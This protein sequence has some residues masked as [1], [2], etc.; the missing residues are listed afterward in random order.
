MN[1][2]KQYQMLQEHPKTHSAIKVKVR[3]VAAFAHRFNITFLLESFNNRQNRHFQV[4]RPFNHQQTIILNK[5]HSVATEKVILSQLH[6][7]TLSSYRAGQ[8]QST[9]VK[10]KRKIR[11]YSY[12]LWHIPV[13]VQQEEQKLQFWVNIF[14]LCDVLVQVLFATSKTK[15][16]IWH[17]KLGIQVLSRVAEQLKIQDLRK[18]G[19]IREI[20]NYGRDIA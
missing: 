6:P 13:T 8:A 17:N 11:R 19:N 2:L 15:P 1:I 18:L 3:C 9:Y 5:T 7:D 20:S 14:E 16:D 12:I 10:P 4:A